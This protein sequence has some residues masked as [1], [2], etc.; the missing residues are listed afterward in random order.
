LSAL[1]HDGPVKFEYVRDSGRVLCEG[2]ATGGR[3]SGPFTVVLNPS[4]VSALQKMGYA[5]PHDDEAFSLVTS[6][7]TLDYARAIRDTGLTSAVSDLIELQ[8]H[9]V[10]SDYI[11]AVRQ[12]G[13]T[14]LT[15]P[16]LSELRDHGVDPNYLK[17]IKA[18]GPDLSIE[19]IDSLFDHG[20]KPDY[21]KSMKATVPQLSIEQI[22]SLFDHGVE[23]DS[24]RGFASVDSKL[25]IRES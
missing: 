17:A 19:G 2:R 24:Y 16:D 13:F 12:E 23:P 6:D 18:A 11:R 22:D 25:S 20:V 4:F 21:Y 5:T 15:A 9:G 14:N 8:D 1:D 10:S 3:A 7:V